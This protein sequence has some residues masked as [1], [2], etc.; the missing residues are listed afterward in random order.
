VAGYAGTRTAAADVATALA[1][2]A[3]GLAAFRQVTPGVLSL[4]PFVASAIARKAALG[5][6]PV[7]IAAAMLAPGAGQAGPLLLTGVG[8][9][10]V[11]LASVAGAFGGIVT[12]P[13]QA[14]LGLHRRR[15]VRLV[16]TLEAQLVG[17]ADTPFVARDHYVARLLD[18]VDVLRAA[19]RLVPR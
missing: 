8:A 4:T 18:L 15:L 7:G 10:L 11:A 3:A 9:G 12:D 14:K 2:L 17:D 5:Q 16:D 19:Q 13:V 1:C 6:A